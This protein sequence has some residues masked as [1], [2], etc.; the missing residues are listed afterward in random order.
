MFYGRGSVSDFIKD[1]PEIRQDTFLTKLSQDRNPR[2]SGTATNLKATG[3][4]HI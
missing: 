3:S 4:V 2:P 1:R